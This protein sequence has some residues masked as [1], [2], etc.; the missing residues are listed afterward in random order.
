MQRLVCGAALSLIDDPLHEIFSKGEH[1]LT[2]VLMAAFKITR[3]SGFAR[4]QVQHQ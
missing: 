4:V 1:M 2:G 3:T